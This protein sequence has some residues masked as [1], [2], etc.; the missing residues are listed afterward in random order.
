MDTVRISHSTNSIVTA[1]DFEEV[2]KPRA[3]TD[4]KQG[5]SQDPSSIPP[6]HPD[7]TIIGS[8][9]DSL[10]REKY[11]TLLKK[12]GR[13]MKIIAVIGSKDKGCLAYAKTIE[14]CCRS[15]GA[16]FERVELQLEGTF[17]NAKMIVE[18]VNKR[19][20]VDV[21]GMIIL[22]PIFGG[23]LV[24]PSLLPGNL[25][26]ADNQDEQLRAYIAP[27]LDIE[28][29]S[30]MMAEKCTSITPIPF[31]RVF[32][33]DGRTTTT[34]FPCTPMSVCTIL[35][36]LQSI[37]DHSVPSDLALH[38]KNVTIINRYVM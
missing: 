29:L 32:S 24:R 5:Q 14:R 37:W 6:P 35:M 15:L 13:T 20:G 28:A 9:L 3:R 31:Q 10:S 21:D 18:G 33:P 38:G 12:G 36:S 30:P 26:K 19:E 16:E 11:Q 23:Q 4:I 1:V 7:L 27:S 2:L 25:C 17:E 34:L 22:T 8:S